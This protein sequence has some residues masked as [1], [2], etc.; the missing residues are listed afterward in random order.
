MPVDIR[1]A[2]RQA[3][4]GLIAEKARIERQIGGV[5]QALRAG[6]GAPLDG[7]RP[8]LRR[9]RARR[10]RRRMSPAARA[11]LSARMKAFWAKREAARARERRRRA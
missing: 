9:A 11:A 6:V 3:L 2:L 1:G 10:V 5:R 7:G 8:I 4:V